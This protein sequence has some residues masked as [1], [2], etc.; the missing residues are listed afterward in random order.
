[1]E[2]SADEY[3][4][5]HTFVL[6]VRTIVEAIGGVPDGIRSDLRTRC[7]RF[8]GADQPTH[9]QPIWKLLEEWL[10]TKCFAEANAGGWFD[11]VM[12]YAY[13]DVR[14]EQAWSLWERTKPDWHRTP[15]ARW[16]TSEPSSSI[17]TSACRQIGIPA[18]WRSNRPELPRILPKD[19]ASIEAG[20]D[21]L[22]HQGVCDRQDDRVEI[23]DRFWPYEKQSPW[24]LALRR[25]S[26]CGK[27]GRLS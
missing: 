3:V 7:P 12:Y 24:L 2:A 10:A 21:E 15:P 25:R 4:E 8:L 23:C 13:K 9:Q 6:W 5:W 22:Q 14:V 26:S 18:E 27:R 1:L 20:L 19:T 11:A 17:F 16:P